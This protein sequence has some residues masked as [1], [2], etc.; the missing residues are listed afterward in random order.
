MPNIAIIAKSPACRAGLIIPAAIVMIM[1]CMSQLPFLN[2]TVVSLLKALIL[3]ATL[4]AGFFHIMNIMPPTLAR[5][6]IE[7]RKKH[8]ED[9]GEEEW[10]TVPFL[11]S[12]LIRIRQAESHY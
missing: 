3:V 4:C 2:G 1:I 5:E 10:E 8:P 11:H 12:F 9:Y 6:E 7:W